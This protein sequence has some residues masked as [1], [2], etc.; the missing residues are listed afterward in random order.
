VSFL[1][2]P[3]AATGIGSLPGT[4]P[5]EATRLILGELTELP[6]LPELPG[7]GPGADMIGRT[8]AQLVDMPVEIAPSGWRLSSHA[9]RDQ[10]R[11]HDF[12]RHDLDALEEQAAGYVGAY[13]VQL[14]GPWTLAASVELPNGN[15]IVS[16]H[17]ATRDLIASAREGAVQLLH[18]VTARVPGAQV[19][20]QWDEPSLPSVLNGTVPTPSGWGSVRAVDVEVARSALHDVLTA[21]AEGGRV[22]HCCAA[23]VP[24]ALLRSAGAD[25][26]S[27]DASLIDRSHYDAI[28]ECVESGMGLW[29]GVVPSVDSEVTFDAAR[30]R[31]QG[32]WQDLGFAMSTLPRAVVPT[33]ACGMA[34]A[35]M[36]YARRALTIVRD[37]G[38][39]LLDLAEA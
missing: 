16:D 39:S 8:A 19:V 15:S 27:V 3:G 23:D 34:G 37:V 31:V 28:G 35:S 24:I 2:T 1:W 11:A 29:L 32:L 14:T 6:H 25:A 9:G 30:A 10:R 21:A 36:P 4:D 33:P 26:L 20:L 38:R 5:V 22:V 17:G 12:L 13:K 7:R 18:E